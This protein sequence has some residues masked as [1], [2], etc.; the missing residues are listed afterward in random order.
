MNKQK[1]SSL[2]LDEYVRVSFYTLL[3]QYILEKGEVSLMPLVSVPA[4]EHWHLKTND[5]I[6]GSEVVVKPT[7][8]KHLSFRTL[9]KLFANCN[10]LFSAACRLFSCF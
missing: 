4:I 1:G 9:T 8:H 10:Y 6:C 5:M 3:V 7:L 2:F